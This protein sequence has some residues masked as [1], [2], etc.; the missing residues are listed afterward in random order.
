M[1]EYKQNLHTHTTFCDGADTPE[2]MLITAI[3]KGFTSIGFSGHSTL[4]YSDQSKVTLESTALYKKEIARLKK[5]Y[6]DR[7]EIFC[8][9][10]FDMYSDDDLSD[11]DYVIGSV[12]Y[13]D[14]GDG[15]FAMDRNLDFVKKLID[16]KFG[17]SGI[18]YAKRFYSELSRLPEFGRFDIVAH[19]DLL[20][21]HSEMAA[22]FD[23]DSKEY[24]D[25]AIGAAEALS[26]KIPFFEVN[27]GAISRG[28]RTTPYPAPF[29]LKELGRLGFGAV[30]SSDC[31]NRNY[32]DCYFEE[33]KELLRSCG[34]TELYYLGKDGFFPTKL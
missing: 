16:E 2:Q 12:H 14:C 10:E 11:L 1:S 27:T 19:F 7:I 34:F 13:L 18:E 29:I 15:V 3:E 33:S 5:E 26:G 4:P 8:G 25:A 30:I 6:E 9:L 24:R 22:L 28:Y 32:L 20:S 23:E 31:H 21:K 17:G